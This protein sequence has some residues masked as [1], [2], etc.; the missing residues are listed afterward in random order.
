[1]DSVVTTVTAAIGQWPTVKSLKRVWSTVK[2]RSEIRSTLTTVGRSV[3]RT[4][5][6]TTTEARSLSLENCS[7]DSNSVA[8]PCIIEGQNYRMVKGQQLINMWRPGNL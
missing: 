3:E 6:D 5:T 8:G 2:A 1:M 4:D 7:V